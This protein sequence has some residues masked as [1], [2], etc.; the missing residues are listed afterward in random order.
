MIAEQIKSFTDEKNGLY[1]WDKD[2]Q[3][4]RK[5]CYKDMVILLRSMSGWSEVFVNV[6][7][8]EGIPATAQTRTGYFATAEVET[9]LGLLSVIDNPMQDIPMAAVLRSPMVGMTDDEMAWMIAAYKRYLQKKQDRGVYGAW[10]LWEE[11]YPQAVSDENPDEDEKKDPE[12]EQIRIGQVEIPKATAKS[13]WKKLEYFA[14]F[15]EE[16][17]QTAGICL[18]MSFFIRSTGK[19]DIMIMCPPCR[20]ERQERPIWICWQKKRQPMLP[21]ATEAYFIL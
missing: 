9:V 15:T 12:T 7:M 17:R 21:P 4:Y 2:G 20:Q 5:A 6:L 1:V 3:S 16:L 14:A 19:Q 8:N 18:S 13:I 11:I 10:K